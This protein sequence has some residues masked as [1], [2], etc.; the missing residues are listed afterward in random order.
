MGDRRQEA[1]DG[2]KKEG[3]GGSGW[4]AWAAATQGDG[5]VGIGLP[6]GTGRSDCNTE[7]RSYKREGS[8]LRPRTRDIGGAGGCVTPQPTGTA[9]HPRVG[10]GGVGTPWVAIS[11]RPTPGRGRLGCRRRK[12]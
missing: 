4:T 1:V 12:W 3:T 7:R 2:Q 6:T 10:A 9:D 11:S 8:A 5:K